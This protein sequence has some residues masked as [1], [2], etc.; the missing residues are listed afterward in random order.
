MA[1]DM[2]N[3]I[4]VQ[5]RTHIQ[6]QTIPTADVESN[7]QH[8]N[9][10]NPYLPFNPIFNKNPSQSIF[11]PTH[12]S[13]TFESHASSYTPSNSKILRTSQQLSTDNSPVDYNKNSP[14]SQ[15]G[16]LTPKL[17]PVN[18]GEN[19]DVSLPIYRE[20]FHSLV[21]YIGL[22]FIDILYLGICSEVLR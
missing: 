12:P 7:I 13:T 15:S 8:S 16:T 9:P 17:R 5:P 3:S 1:N 6:T 21:T 4:G 11:P 18:D 2:H 20:I 14:A 10:V 22:I 19:E